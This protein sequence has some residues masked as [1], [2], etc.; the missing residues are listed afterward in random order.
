LYARRINI[1]GKLLQIPPKEMT[2]KRC[3]APRSESPKGN[4]GS[5]PRFSQ[6]LIKESFMIKTFQTKTVFP[7]LLALLLTFSCLW[8]Q[9]AD[10][11]PFDSPRWQMVNAK[12]ADYLGQKA[13]M[14]TVFLKDSEF[15]NGVIEF[16]LAVT[17]ARSYPGVI[18]RSQAN[19][20]WERIYIRPHRA[21]TEPTPLY[22]D[23][24]QYV[25]SFNRVDS[26][27]FYNG[28]GMTAAA[29][30]PFNRWFHVKIEVSGTQARVFLDKAETPAL[31]IHE[32]KQGIR[33]GGLGLIGPMDGSAYYANFSYYPDNNLKFLPPPPIYPVAGVIRVW[34]LS[35]PFKALQIDM[36]KNPAEQSLGDLDWKAASA[37]ASGLVDISRFHPRSGAPDL[38]FAKTVIDSQEEKTFKLNIGYSDYISVF[39]NGKLLFT[40]ASPYQGRDPSFLGIVGFFDSVYLPLQKGNNELLLAV[41]ELSGGWGFKAQDG[42]ALAAAANVARVWETQKKFLLPESAAYDPKSKALYVSNNDAYNRSQDEGRQSISK[43]SLNGQIEKLDWVSGLKNP[44]G[45]AVFRNILYVVEA[46]SLVEIDIA[47]A[48]IIKRHDVPGAVMLNDI[49]ISPKGTIFMSDF[50][51]NIIFKFAKGQFEEWLKSPEV[52]NPNGVSVSG[53]N[54][55][56]GNC[57]DGNLKVVDLT[58]KEIKTIA[59]LGPGIIDG[60]LVEASGNILASKNEGQL[61]R[62]TPAGQTSLLLDTTVIAQNLADFTFIPE[63]GLVIFPTWLDGRVT[64]FRLGK[65]D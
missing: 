17:G 22:A 27:Q 33:K 16:D 20:S 5:L 25:S 65:V 63:L 42:S 23:V 2:T 35:R 7:F 40:G 52:S 59:N 4:G 3:A 48:Q 6:L 15:E 55:F 64:A 61:F 13:L 51:K 19:G 28:E 44:T 57:G 62:V 29:A 31:L 37:E 58:S 60:V 50:R 26:W 9:A 49:T 53:K 10:T 46:K 11:I 41:A 1:L 24:L 32:L 14:G 47:K 38:V 54:L 30:I 39:L 8:A 36:E 56:W 12:V 43:I 34:E 21:G 45:L 18:F